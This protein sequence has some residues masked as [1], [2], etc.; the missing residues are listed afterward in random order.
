MRGFKASLVFLPA[1]GL[2]WVFGFLAI[3]QATETM[4]Y[5]FTIFNSLQGLLLFLFHVLL[6]PSCRQAWKDL[7][8]RDRNKF[9]SSSA[10][11]APTKLVS[12]GFA[13]TKSS[14]VDVLEET[15][16][17]DMPGSSV[18]PPRR[19]SHFYPRGF[20]DTDVMLYNELTTPIRTESRL[21]G[22]S[23]SARPVSPN[24]L[25]LFDETDLSAME[26]RPS[27]FCALFFLKYVYMYHF[28]FGLCHVDS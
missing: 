22:S 19:S 24:R 28:V 23:S 25:S 3:E 13:P 27:A 9:F 26:P 11:A 17:S 8:C 1:M 14:K 4:S 2:T 16:F 7:F 12:S 10:S 15:D 6:D 5:L 20:N 18:A 21:Q